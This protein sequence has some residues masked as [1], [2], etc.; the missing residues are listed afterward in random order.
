MTVLVWALLS[1]GAFAQ[2][3]IY[4]PT[5][6][7]FITTAGDFAQARSYLVEVLPLL[8]DE[9]LLSWE[10]PVAQ[11]EFISEGNYRIPLSAVVSLP[12]GVTYRYRLRAVGT[13]TISDPSAIAP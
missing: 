12:V 7:E 3:A 4:N 8:S 10:V 13:A 1:A 9:P 5:R 6:I 11:I 2:V